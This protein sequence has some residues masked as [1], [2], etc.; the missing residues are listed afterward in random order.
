ML[1]TAPETDHTRK[2][3]I[4]KIKQIIKSRID[5]NT[6]IAN[7][8]ITSE[9]KQLA[10]Q[11]YLSHF[12]KPEFHP[13]FAAL[14]PLIGFSMAIKGCEADAKKY[15]HFLT[16]CF[17]LNNQDAIINELFFFAQSMALMEKKCNGDEFQ[18]DSE[19]KYFRDIMR[20][21]LPDFN[22]D[23]SKFY[24]N[25]RKFEVKSAS[26]CTLTIDL[27]RAI[28]D[29]MEKCSTLKVSSSSE[30][31]TKIERKLN[32]IIA[33]SRES[34][35]VSPA[36]HEVN[37]QPLLQDFSPANFSK[38]QALYAVYDCH[39]QL[40]AEEK[41]IESS[42]AEIT[43]CIQSSEEEHISTD[44]TPRP[45]E[46]PLSIESKPE[47]ISIEV[48]SLFEKDE[49]RDKNQSSTSSADAILSTSSTI[50]VVQPLYTSK[51]KM[52]RQEELAKMKLRKEDKKS[53][54]QENQ[55][56]DSPETNAK[57]QRLNFYREKLAHFKNLIENIF[58]ENVP[59]LEIRWSE[60]ERMMNAIGAKITEAE[61]SRI[62]LIFQE[63]TIHEKWTTI[64]GPTNVSQR[65]IH[66]SHIPGKS[67]DRIA[68]I[69]VEILRKALVRFKLTPQELWPEREVAPGLK[70]LRL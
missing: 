33:K 18:L 26:R 41:L 66:K 57:M 3:A 19:S 12:V 11:I 34:R 68:G 22:R 50:S 52:Q 59:H 49:K 56:N 20:I 54:A 70:I 62:T 24:T 67:D 13:T 23:L 47:N 37:G 16:W 36:F 58:R 42:V 38:M 51:R 39:Q 7:Y 8:L 5:L 69:Y 30:V 2:I 40:L 65:G 44:S 61:G 46:V 21:C 14:L 63:N 25:Y 32:K 10:S 35:P 43:P 28:D 60:V 29:C 27:Q 31:L 45:Q 55:K 48:L 17:N 4:R 15:K 6:E 53:N 64:L 9:N 1:N